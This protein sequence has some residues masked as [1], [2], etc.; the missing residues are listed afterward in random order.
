MFKIL[1][2]ETPIQDVTMISTPL[3]S[4]ERTSALLCILLCSACASNS[5]NI[6]HGSDI[7][8]MSSSQVSYMLERRLWD[9]IYSE[10]NTVTV[11]NDS[12]SMIQHFIYN[13]V[14]RIFS[15][16]VTETRII[17]AESA[18]DQFAIHLL[19]AAEGTDPAGGQSG[20]KIGEGTFSS[21]QFKLCPLYPFC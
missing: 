15:Y 7:S 9:R 10:N 21:A 6:H 4:F 8:L 18:I 3:K 14:D 5:P 2:S 16:G 19:Q 20:I 1:E 17:Q 12:R 13:G 11:T